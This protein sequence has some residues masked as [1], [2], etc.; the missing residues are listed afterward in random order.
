MSQECSPDIVR[1]ALSLGALGYVEKLSAARDLLP[2]I[3]AVLSGRRFVSRS[4]AFAE[5]SDVSAQQR[6]ELIF[7]PDETALI[8]ILARYIVTALN[9]GHA[10]VLVV[11]ESDRNRVLQRLRAQDVDID[12][13]IGRGLFRPLDD[14][15]LDG[16]RLGE[17]ID[18]ARDAASRA[19]AA[20]PRV[21]LCGNHSGR[22][23]ADGRTEEALQLEQCCRVFPRDL[24]ILCVYPV[25]H[26]KDDQALARI[27][28][29]HTAVLTGQPR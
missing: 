21:V 19:G 6:H 14:N 17:A 11:R 5:P 25:P 12:D 27:C 4:V 18:I 3:D 10:A 28:A 2:A 7:C 23:W 29:E 9:G 8:D 15:G 24:D 20:H 22:L 1:K 26:D 13:A 16:V